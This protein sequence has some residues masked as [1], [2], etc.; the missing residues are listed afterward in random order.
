MKNKKKFDY[1]AAFVEFTQKAVQA[2]E[3]L[4]RCLVDFKPEEVQMYTDKIHEIEH[5]AD[6]IKHSVTE[7]LSREFISPI[8]REDII[9]LV[10]E[11][12]NVV[13]SIDDVIRKFCIYNV[14]AVREDVTQFTLLMTDCCKKLNSLAEEFKDFRKSKNIKSL[15]IEVNTIETTADT[16]HFDAVSRLFANEE[17]APVLIAWKSIYDTLEACFDNCEHAAEI[18]DCVILKN[19]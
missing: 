6:S 3:L 18:M 15:I 7:H 19:T 5:S 12:D 2:S 1:F 4:H 11:F 17:A 13:D 14:K 8:E 16:L 9:A 10:Q